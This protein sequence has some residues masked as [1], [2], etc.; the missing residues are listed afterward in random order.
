MVDCLVEDAEAEDVLFPVRGFGSTREIGFVMFRANHFRPIGQG[1]LS[2][3]LLCQAC[4]IYVNGREKRG[5]ER[6]KIDQ[7][8]CIRGSQLRRRRAVEVIA[9]SASDGA[10]ELREAQLN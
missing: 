1:K 5:K 4:V 9:T 10:R 2:G 3:A 7:N 6:D 8:G